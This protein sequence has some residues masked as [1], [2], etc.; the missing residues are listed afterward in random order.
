[1]LTP[2]QIEELN[3]FDRLIQ[4]WAKK[5]GLDCYPQEFDIIDSEKMAE[6]MTSGSLP[7]T[8]NHWSYGRDFETVKTSWRLNRFNLPMETVYNANPCRG[9]ICAT[10]PFVVMILVIA[11]V[12][13]HN[14]FFKNNF[15]L[16]Q[17]RK[18][19]LGFMADAARR[20]KKYENAYGVEEVEKTL[21]AALSL[22]WNIEPFRPERPDFQQQLEAK[23]LEARATA[24]KDQKTL[25]LK[26]LRADMEKQIP[27]EHDRDVI[28]FIKDV[29]PT[30]EDWQ[31]DILAVV[32]EQAYYLFPNI[33]TQ[34]MNE[35]WA[36]YWHEKIMDELIAAELIS[37]A[38]R[39]IYMTTQS[40]VLA[41][42]KIDQNPYWLGREIWKHI[43]QKHGLKKAF[44]VRANYRDIEFV[45]EFL[46]DELI[47][48]L[49]LY[50]Y[51]RY[52]DRIDGKDVY[53]YEIADK[54]PERTRERIVASLKKRPDAPVIRV[55]RS[56]F[57]KNGELLLLH[58]F[59][60]NQEELDGEHLARTLEHV[61]H[62]WG[63]PVWL[64]TREPNVRSSSGFANI[65]YG[66]DGARHQKLLI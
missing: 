27:F 24:K 21:T 10:D 9:Y 47:R 18:D 33:R 53:V 48:R 41:D 30:L 65:L 66:Y 55:T 11:H 57:N 16:L 43:V 22:Q 52:E 60:E 12:Y 45:E 17:G 59:N 42:W 26:K 31:R 8:F 49:K 13:G 58:D 38:D 35:G 14:D 25:D 2:Q 61:Y 37:T 19:I 62:L 46:E 40:R 6:L 63:K 34:T 39:D 32:R 15:W 64:Q 50:I 44:D 5:F 56:N 54:N 29:S 1:M 7:I 51:G 20:F 36:V 3:R 23:I 28:G 4:D